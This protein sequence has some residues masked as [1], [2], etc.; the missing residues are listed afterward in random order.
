MSVLPVPGGPYMSAPFGGLMPRLAKRS[1]CVIGSTIASMSSWIWSSRPPTSLNCS[2]GFSSTSIALTRE[3]NSA[4]SAS[5][6]RYESLFTP[7]RSAG[8][9]L[10]GSTRPGTGRKMVCLVDVLSTQHL[11]LRCASRS[12]FAPSSS[13]SSSG[14]MS[15]SSTTFATRYGSCL[16]SLIFSAFSLIFSFC[17]CCSCSSREF[18]FRSTLISFSS[19]RVRCAISSGS[20]RAI[21]SPRS[22]PSSP[23]PKMSVVSMSVAA[24]AADSGVAMTQTA[25]RSPGSP[26][27]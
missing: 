1:L 18:S 8:L 27:R 3:S 6:M 2:V 23:S 17:V 20:A 9:R 22:S 14:S 11:P 10:S 26:E 24:G 13:G 16:L 5:R 15:S 21:S 7:T 19:I 25:R 4:G 12:M